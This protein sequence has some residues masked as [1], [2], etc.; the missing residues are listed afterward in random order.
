[1]ESHLFERIGKLFFSESKHIHKAIQIKIDHLNTQSLEDY[2]K[3][4]LS[5]FLKSKH[6]PKKSLKTKI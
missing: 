5:Y 4:E 2:I 3:V 6:I 1:M